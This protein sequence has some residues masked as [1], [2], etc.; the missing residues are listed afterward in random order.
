MHDNYSWSK[1]GLA[2]FTLEKNLRGL[3]SGGVGV[4]KRN[5]GNPLEKGWE[6]TGAAYLGIPENAASLPFVEILIS[7]HKPGTLPLSSCLWING[8]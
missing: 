4:M 3:G 6:P 7:L 2:G 8:K 5:E 1:G